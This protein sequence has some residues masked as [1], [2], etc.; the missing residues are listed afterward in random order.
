LHAVGFW[1]VLLTG[2]RHSR[3]EAQPRRRHPHQL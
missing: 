3:R 1:V 2:Y